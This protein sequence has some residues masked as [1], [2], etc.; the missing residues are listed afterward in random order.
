MGRRSRCPVY[1]SASSTSCPTRRVDDGTVQNI[2]DQTV[3]NVRASNVFVR[4]VTN[5][6]WSTRAALMI[7]NVRGSTTTNVFAHVGNHGECRR[8]VAQEPW[9]GYL[10]RRSLR[11]RARAERSARYGRRRLASA[12]GCAL[13]S[14]AGEAPGNLTLEN[15]VCHGADDTSDPG[16][17]FQTGPVANSGVWE[18]IQPPETIIRNTVFNDCTAAL[19]RTGTAV[20]LTQHN[21][22]VSNCGASLGQHR[23]ANCRS[24]VRRP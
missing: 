16:I 8:T 22:A 10:P 18:T 9:P 6:G 11:G 12:R 17:T 4:R 13:I 5:S 14:S 24:K 1:A 21:N 23:R 19:K 3:L 2:T 15:W 7:D 20:S